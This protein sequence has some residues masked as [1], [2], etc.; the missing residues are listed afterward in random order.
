M[1]AEG[2]RFEP[3]I[4]HQRVAGERQKTEDIGPGGESLQGDAFCSLDRIFNK[5]EEVRKHARQEGHVSGL[6]CINKQHCETAPW[7]GRA[8]DSKL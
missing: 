5:S 6:Y 8:E 1:Q 3:V 4:L 2:R 7:S